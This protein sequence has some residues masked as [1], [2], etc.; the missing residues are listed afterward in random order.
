[1]TDLSIR[2]ANALQGA[3]PSSEMA[4]IL[5]EAMAAVGVAREAYAQAEA[6]ALDPL[7]EPDQVATARRTMDDAKFSMD[8]LANGVAALNKRFDE[9]LK[10]EEAAAW[11]VAMDAAEK[12]QRAA[13]DRLRDR[14]PELAA[15][16]ADILAECAAADRQVDRRAGRFRVVVLVFWP[17]MRNPLEAIKL[18]MPTGR[19]WPSKGWGIR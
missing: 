14:Y 17:G 19:A 13:A 6:V 4:S 16:I 10:A 3:L 9:V 15:E 2:I 7:T 11:Q 1:M 8:R 5:E 18:P 12:R